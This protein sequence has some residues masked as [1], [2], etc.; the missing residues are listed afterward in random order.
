MCASWHLSHGATLALGDANDSFQFCRLEF[1]GAGGPCKNYHALLSPLFVMQFRRSSLVFWAASLFVGSFEP[2]SRLSLWAPSSY[3]FV[4]P[5]KQSGSNGSLQLVSNVSYLH[6]R[7]LLN[8]HEGDHITSALSRRVWQTGSTVAGS[9][10]SD[11]PWKVNAADLS[12]TAGYMALISGC[13]GS[14]S[15]TETS[16]PTVLLQTDATFRV[17]QGKRA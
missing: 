7:A 5:R 12:V 1:G 13:A 9:S 8:T 11:E 16:S 15:G 17:S 2:E 4:I 14:V 3:A 10:C 6:Q